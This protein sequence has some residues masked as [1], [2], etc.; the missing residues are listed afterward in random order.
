MTALLRNLALACACA[1]LVAACGTAAT[2]EVVTLEASVTHSYRKI[3]VIAMSGS[4]D[5]RRVFDDAMV[6][7]L[8][9]AGVE[10]VVGDRYIEDAAVANGIEPMIAVRATGADAVM[11]VWL[12][13]SNESR[14]DPSPGSWGWTGTQAAW[15]PSPG[16]TAEM[17]S[18]FE[19]RL[20]DLAS[21]RL[22]W[23]GYTATFYPRSI[24]EDAPRIAD[25][26]VVELGKRGLVRPG[27]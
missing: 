7:R 13:R 11:Y 10:G 1:A 8:V 9:A 18:R 4:K 20:Y 21:Q 16:Q 6:T 5:E 22:A 24:G 3:A 14:V 12:R 19:V 25:R 17:M 23:S 2:T 26:V 27:G 15:Y